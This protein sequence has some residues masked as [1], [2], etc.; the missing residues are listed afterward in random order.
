MLSTLRY[1]AS[2]GLVALSSFDLPAQ[3]SPS[4]APVG[5]GIML[6]PF[7]VVGSRLAAP[8]SDPAAPAAVILDR[9]T[10]ERVGA[11]SLDDLLTRLPFTYSGVGDGIGTVPNGAPFYGNAL[12]LT[13]FSTGASAPLK[14]TGV[15]AAGLRGL[16]AAGTLVLIDGRRLPL[17]TQEDTASDTGAGFYD[18]SAIP[19]GLVDR[20]EVLPNGAS[21]VHG[22]D[23]VGGVV[24]VVLRRNFTGGEIT[25]GLRATEAGGG[26]E[27]HAAVSAGTRQG[28]FSLFVTVTGRSQEALPASSR[29]FSASSDQ[30][31]RGGRNWN[32]AVG[33]PPVLSATAGTFPGLTD[34]NGNP[35]RHALVP[36]DQDGSA[37]TAADFTGAAPQ[38]GTSAGTIRTLDAAPYRDLFG[39]LEQA[40]FNAAAAYAFNA[41]LEAYARVTGSDRT[42]VTAHEPA[43]IVGGGFGGANTLVP[44]DNPRNPFGQAVRVSLALVEFPARAQTVDVTTTQTV[45]GLRGAFG[46]GWQWDAALTHARERFDSRTAE[47]STAAFVGSLADGSFNPFGD[48]LTHGPLN[49][50]LAGTLFTDARIAGTSQITG[51]DAF[52]RGPVL[53]LP[54]GPL[55]LAV[56]GETRRAER[57]RS[58]TNPV[59]GQPADVTSARTTTAVFAETYLPL[60]GD[61]ATGPGLRRLGAR[62]AARYEKTADFAETTPSLGLAWTPWDAVT[63][64]A[65]YAEGFR[66]PSLTELEDVVRTGTTTIIDP[67][68][69]GERYTVAYRRG[70]NLD[71]SAETSRTY[72]F[73][74]SVTPPF[75]AGLTFHARS[76]ETYYNN[77]LNTLTEQLFVSFE[78][79]FPDRVSRDTS[80]RVTEVD[81]TTV[82]F[83]K[84]YL[85]AADLGLAYEHDFGDLGRITV[86]LDATR[87]LA[88]RTEMR[89]DLAGTVTADGEDT[90]SPPKWKAFGLLFWNRGAWDVAIT[91]QHLDGFASNSSG[92]FFDAAT[93][94]PSFTTVDLRLGYTFAERGWRGWG[95]NTRVQLGV[96]NLADRTPPFANSTYGYNQSLHSPLGRTYDVSVRLPF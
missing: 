71:V 41:N 45:A 65:D 52:A 87:Q 26:F 94:Y 64:T 25:A 28:P 53:D 55:T 91:A 6:D 85:R 12:A 67:L 16:G 58:S 50:H 7:P 14:Q 93:A 86:R 63:L 95:K 73:G 59:F 23:A 75:L 48:P 24:N 13:N 27:R 43:T 20:I 51:F 17:A 72:Q 36:G 62:L 1:L 89:P 18:L 4:A 79:R 57:Q 70:G 11:L 82:N 40:G 9:A 21:A 8:E 54:A 56:G 44:A 34:Q 83:G 69:A 42:S 31:A 32:L 80:G 76:Y 30:T 19:L 33:N 22:S 29:P 78:E 81:N 61:D 2:A 3:G 46:E 84:V 88:Y 35:A 38:F 96:G 74:L 39:S 37:L 10:I 68:L 92:S 77:K 5:E 66:A 47:L 15:S 60:L 49:A 90:V